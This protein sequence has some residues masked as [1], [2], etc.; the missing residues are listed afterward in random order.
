MGRQMCI[1]DRDKADGCGTGLGEVLAAGRRHIEAA[2]DDLAVMIEAKSDVVVVE[3]RPHLCLLYTSLRS[4]RRSGA[5]RVYRPH[6][7]PAPPSAPL[8]QLADGIRVAR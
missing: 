2:R 4:S 3:V 5:D 1:R 8:A 7:A 6:P